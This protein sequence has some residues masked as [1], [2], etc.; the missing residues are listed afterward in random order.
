MISIF[1]DYLPIILSCIAA[2]ILFLGDRFKWKRKSYIIGIVALLFFGA[3]ATG[4]NN[5]RNDIKQAKLLSLIKQSGSDIGKLLEEVAA[6]NV[7]I[8]IILERL[9]SIR[10]DLNSEGKNIILVSGP[11]GPQGEQGLAGPEGTRGPKGD[12]GDPGDKTGLQGPKGDNGDPGDPGPQGLQGEQGLTG[13]EGPQGSKGD[14]GDP[15]VKGTRGPKGD[16][17]DPG[18]K[19]LQEL[20]GRGDIV[21]PA[22]L[23]GLQVK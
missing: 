1:P 13:L 15:G 19:V 18:D 22:P 12:K 10:E 6:G 11:Q 16:K 14:K 17:G 7:D 9:E 2:I 23:Q 5:W 3:V 21:P 20:Q 8:K 4:F